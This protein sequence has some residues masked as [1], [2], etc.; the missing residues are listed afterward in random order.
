MVNYSK[1]KVCN[2]LL[3]FLCQSWPVMRK[4]LFIPSNHQ[5]N[6]PSHHHQTPLF[7]W[8]YNESNQAIYLPKTCFSSTKAWYYQG[9]KLW[10]TKFTALDFAC[11]NYVYP[12][13]PGYREIF[14]KKN[15]IP[16]NRMIAEQTSG[17]C[18]CGKSILCF[19]IPGNFENFDSD[20]GKKT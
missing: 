19:W 18:M 20:T 5:L 1:R 8:P 15:W 16:G 9:C 13:Y 14:R 11:A 4:Y 7:G 6:I 3:Q 17:K 12:R 10:T 2:I